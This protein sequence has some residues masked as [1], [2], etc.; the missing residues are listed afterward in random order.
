[1]V[2]MAGFD[3]PVRAIREQIASALNIVVHTA[4]L[5]DGSRKVTNVSEVVGM[6]GEMITT[7]EI[8]RYDQRGLD[9]DSKVIGDFVYSGVQPS[10]MKRFEEYGISYDVRS[11]SELTQAVSW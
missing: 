2:L 4:R 9:K 1:M 11:L 7:Q 10:C 3:L 6:E 5:R 8:I